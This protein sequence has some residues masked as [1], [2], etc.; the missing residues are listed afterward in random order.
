MNRLNRTGRHLAGG[1]SKRLQDT[2]TPLLVHTVG[3]DT[4]KS[5]LL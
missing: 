1:W 2:L 5:V 4:D 3:V